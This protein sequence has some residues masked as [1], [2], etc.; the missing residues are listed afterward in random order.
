MAVR[1]PFGKVVVAV[2]SLFVVS[3]GVLGV[4]FT[5]GKVTVEQPTVER[6][7]TDWGVVTADETE[8]QT[9]IVL[10]NPNSVGVPG[11]V[12]LRY[13]IGMND[14]VLSDESKPKSIEI[15]PHSERTI[16][17]TVPLD[18]SK[19]GAWW[20]THLRRGEKSTLAVSY[21]VVVEYRGYSQKVALDSLKYEKTM[22]IDVLGNETA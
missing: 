12:D 1:S 15:A 4:A 11:V 5:S 20:K 16:R 9:E 10:N 21:Y 18:N 14:V 19:L 6:V 3:T 17:D 2:L 7:Q 8:I 13:A 22:T